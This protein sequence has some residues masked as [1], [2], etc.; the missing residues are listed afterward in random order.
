MKETDINQVSI[1]NDRQLIAVAENL[2]RAKVFCYPAYI[3]RQN[4]YS[5]DHGHTSHVVGAQFM[6]DD[7]FLVTVGQNDCAIMVWAYRAFG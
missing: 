5:L 4:Y 2:G 1:S 3:P 7:S 6:P